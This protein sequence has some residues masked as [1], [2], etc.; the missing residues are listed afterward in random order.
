MQPTDVR[1]VAQQAIEQ[2]RAFAAQM[3]ESRVTR[4]AAQLESLTPGLRGLSEMLRDTGTP[5]IAADY[6]DRGADTVDLAA[7]YL[8][9]VDAERLL[10]DAEEF[11]RRRPWTVAAGALVAGFAASRFIKSSSTRRYRLSSGYASHAVSDVSN[12]GGAHAA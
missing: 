7:R 8:Q 5:P 10:L 4:L 3:L 6:L 2:S 12:H 1:D 11:A 9:E